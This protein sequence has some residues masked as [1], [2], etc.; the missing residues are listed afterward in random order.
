[1]KQIDPKSVTPAVVYSTMIRA[2]NPRP[3]AWVSTLSPAGISNLAP[4]SY[5]NGIGSQP[6]ALMFS[7]VNHPDGRKKDTTRNIESSGQFVV[8]I[9][10]FDHVQAV[11]S[12][13]DAFD[14]E[15]SELEALDL[16][17]IASL[18]VA[19]PRVLE[20][21]VHLECELFQ[22]V[23]VGEG[24]LAANLFIGKILMMHVD[25]T[26]LDENEKIQPEALDTIGRMGG[27][28]YCRTRD[29]FLP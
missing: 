24:P 8:N 29:R 27:R 10:S 9:P 1:M 28:A 3:I 19:P 11:Q 22:H 5:F 2:I 16:T 18:K 17:P 6:A 7:V 25:E 14:Y 4:F 12:S 23:V 15:E 21:R 26:V 13:A 20:C